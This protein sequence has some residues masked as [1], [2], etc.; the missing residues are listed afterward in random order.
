MTIEDPEIVPEKIESDGRG[1]YA[2]A[3]LPR[4]YEGPCALRFYDK[5]GGHWVKFTTRDAAESAASG[6][7]RYDVGGYSNVSVHPANA[8]PVDV[9]LYRSALSWLFEGQLDDLDEGEEYTAPTPANIIRRAMKELARSIAQAPNALHDVE[10]RDLERLLG[11][12]FEGL[13]FKTTVTRSGKDGAYDLHL[14]AEDRTYLVELKHWS[15][16]SKVGMR[17][18]KH[19]A[20]VAIQQEATGMLIA[21]GGFTNDVLRGRLEIAK[22]SVVLGDQLKVISLCQYFILSESGLWTPETNLKDLFFEFSL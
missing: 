4:G 17:I 14:E 16:R 8:A 20:E 7:C 2:L 1:E 6:A 9:P 11:E 5:S 18:V 3:F 22:R 12:V 13:G 21:T 15:D 19:F 10:W